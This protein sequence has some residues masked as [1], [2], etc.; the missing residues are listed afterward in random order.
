MSERYV[1]RFGKKGYKATYNYFCLGY[2]FNIGRTYSLKSKPV[3][4]CRGFHYCKEAKNTLNYYKYN[5]SDFKLLEIMDLGES[6]HKSGNK[7]ATN[8]IKILRE[9]TDPNEIFEL[10]NQYRAYDK[11]GKV[12]HSIEWIRDSKVENK[13]DSNQ[14][15]IYYKNHTCNVEKSFYPSKTY[16]E[17][18]KTYK[19][20][21]EE[22]HY[23]R[24]G[25]IKQI[26]DFERGVTTK[27]NYVKKNDKFIL[28]SR[29]SSDGTCV[30][31][32][33]KE[34][35]YFQR[36]ADRNTMK[37]SFNE[38][39]CIT[40]V[41]YSDGPKEE[42]VWNKYNL[43]VSYSNTDGTKIENKYRGKNLIS[44]TEVIVK[45]FK[46]GQRVNMFHY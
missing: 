22:I 2:K 39:G 35:I 27:Y 32:N 23:Y 20:S 24:D 29:T 38:V 1:N 6:T 40:K 13:Y 34:Q 21:A 26:T 5:R 16:E 10:L 19:T 8:K 42:F 11:N 33:D 37:V 30:K 15:V 17:N 4:C 25:R 45:K 3:A 31:Y 43:L 36:F 14:N 12:I 18:L 41:V 46:E 9:I 7:F 44:S 28:R